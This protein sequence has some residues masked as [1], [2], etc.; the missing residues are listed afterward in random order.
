M[1]CL[2]TTYIGLLFSCLV[3]Q[4]ACAALI[5]TVDARIANTVDSGM[6]SGFFNGTKDEFDKY[7]QVSTLAVN[8]FTI[9]F[10]T[11]ALETQP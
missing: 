1:K 9:Q 8:R 11:F 3:I 6:G 2:L 7:A 4:L 5:F 10:L